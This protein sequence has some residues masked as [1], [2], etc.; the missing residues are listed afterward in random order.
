V[1]FAPLNLL[2][3]SLNIMSLGGLA[4]GVGMLVDNSI[5][6]LES[7]FRCRDEGDD[8]RAAAIRGRQE[9]GMAVVASTLT[10]VA[11]FFPLVF[12]EGIA[13][14]A[15]GD[16]GIAVVISLVASLIVAVWFIP[17]LA[18]RQRL[19]LN[20]MAG[21]GALWKRFVA[22]ERIRDSLGATGIVKWLLLP[23]TL[24]R[25]VVGLLLEVIGKLLLTLF[26]LLALLVTRVLAPAFLFFIRW[27]TWLPLK[28]ANGI[29]DR[30]NRIYP[31]CIRWSLR[32]PAIIVGLTAATFYVTWAAATRLQ[33]ELLPEVHQGEFTFEVSLPVG[34][35]IE[36]TEAAL[37]SV[38]RAILASKEDIRTLLVT[39]GFDVTNMKR[40]DEGEH[41]ARFK[42]VLERGRDPIATEER[43]LARLRE[44]FRDIPDVDVRVVRPV[45]FSSKTPIV[46]EIN[47]D[48][49]QRLKQLSRQAEAVM[50][51]L[52]ELA[53]VESSL[54]SGAPEIQVLYHRDKLSLYG[55]RIATVAE[56]VRSMVKGFEAS[57]FNL[58]DRRIPIVVR[59]EESDREF[60]E[61]IGTLTV[62]AGGQQ[63]IPLNTI[64]DLSIGEGPSEVRRIDSRRVALVQANIAQGSLGAAVQRI[65]EEL[66]RR[67]DW[68]PDMDFAITGQNEEWE[69]SKG[70]LYL[71]LALS[72]FLVYVIMAAQFESLLQPLI[73]MLTIPLA[74]L[75]SVAGLLMLDI[76]VSVVVFLGLIM[77]AGIVVNNAIVLVDY[78]NTLKKRGL[79]RIEAIVTA[80]KVR[81]RPI[82]MTTATTVLGLL[83]M[84]L[85]L[86]D[87]AEIRTPM[88]VTVICG[89]ITS[90][91]L[92]L[93]VIPA[94]YALVKGVDLERAPSV[95]V[96]PAE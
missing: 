88:A 89:L 38:E 14:Q 4:L 17:M 79:D 66:R 47:G 15:F 75:G 8:V 41:S 73:I 65:D 39:F 16:L 32:N 3:V 96:V 91:V 22:W 26:M 49:L 67:M 71:A 24:L 23:W 93:I 19:E 9:V 1:T 40:S 53:D 30:L 83:P 92:T 63:P 77:L 43:V 33:T 29:L 68:P 52:P 5:V 55:L 90:T 12:V 54:R 2:G 70:S 81:L 18:S 11:V 72:L 7:I 34:T 35:P 76:S 6:V 82:L 20:D 27:T 84:A 46:V 59:L 86:G 25:F 95:A 21:G 87:G 85:G 69:R 37:S 51:Q 10:S 31:V 78:V 57:R 42:V 50:A 48:D 64:A 44:F 74:F 13:G 45:L 62:N 61:D 60:A 28:A 36:E 58:K 80:G 56:Q 94:V